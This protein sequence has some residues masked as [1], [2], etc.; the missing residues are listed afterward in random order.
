MRINF[1]ALESALIDQPK[2]PKDQNDTLDD[3]LADKLIEAIKCDPKVKQR[4][5]VDSH[6]APLVF[7]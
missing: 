4:S 3:T 5:T 6:G 1:R 7:M 2:V